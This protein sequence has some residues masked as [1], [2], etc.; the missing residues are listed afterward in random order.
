M[1]QIKVSKKSSFQDVINFINDKIGQ[2]EET[3]AEKKD[4]L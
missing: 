4:E 2:G 3:G 1:L